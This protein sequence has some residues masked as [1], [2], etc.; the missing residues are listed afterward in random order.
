M[1]FF[2]VLLRSEDSSRAYTTYQRDHRSRRVWIFTESF[3]V[4]E[5][6][7]RIFLLSFKSKEDL[8]VVLDASPWCYNGTLIVLE[9]FRRHT[10]VEDYKL[11][12]GS[13]WI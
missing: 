4:C 11:H 3:E 10:P 12:Y 2:Q 1:F 5:A 13:L 9:R 8:L 7:N 6:K